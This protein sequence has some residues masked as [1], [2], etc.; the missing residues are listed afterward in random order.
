MSVDV[1]DIPIV[2]EIDHDED[3][4]DGTVYIHVGIVNSDGNQCSGSAAAHPELTPDDIAR[5]II[6]AALGAAAAHSTDTWI[7]LQ[8]QL[9]QPPEVSG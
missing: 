8:Q 2:T 5:M 6:R 9:A 1:D 3:G 7:A 4:D